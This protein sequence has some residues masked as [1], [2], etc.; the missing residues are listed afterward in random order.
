MGEAREMAAEF[1]PLKTKADLQ[2]LVD[3]AVEE[4]I[5]L[6]YKASPAL[7]RDSKQSDEMCKDVSA[8]ANSAG[9]Q[10]IY[11]VEEEKKGIPSALDNGIT[12]P[13]V[14]REWIIQVLN[15]RVQPKMIGITV[16]RIKLS[17][18]GFGFVINVPQ[19][20]TGPHQ[21]PDK[22]YYR[23]HEL[24]SQP[25]EDYE[26]RDVMNRA[27]T[28]ELYVR[29]GFPNGH[30]HKLGFKPLKEV[31]EGV[32]LSFSIGNHSRQPAEYARI[33]IGVD[34]DFDFITHNFQNRRPRVLEG[35]NYQTFVAV[36]SVLEKNIPIFK[37][38]DLVLKEQVTIGVR[39][40]H[41]ESTLFRLFIGIQSPGFSSLDRY[42]IHCRQ[43]ALEI[44]GPI[45][46]N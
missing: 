12:D 3:D 28:P 16:E 5:Q 8:F 23:R 44:R 41:V 25:M 35:E 6:D 17:E 29:P 40:E 45:P 30:K 36:W 43:A 22:K 46:Q 18:D 7:T 34:A 13:K 21:A 38:A 2:K 9:G 39:S 26:I 1:I 10:I 42:H 11:G 27:V 20:N 37:E 4:S 14:T 32:Q 24:L 33:L 15:S 31:S 19:T